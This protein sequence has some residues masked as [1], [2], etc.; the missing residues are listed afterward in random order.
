VRRH[1]SQS[2]AGGS[3]SMVSVTGV[4]FLVTSVAC[5]AWAYAPAATSTTGRLS[6]VDFQLRFDIDVLPLMVELD[7]RYADPKCFPRLLPKYLDRSLVSFLQRR[8]AFRGGTIAYRPRQF[9]CTKARLLR[10]AT[11]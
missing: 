8:A 4:K 2:D 3:R 11:E 5:G 7:R 6:A 1:I 9:Q 10:K